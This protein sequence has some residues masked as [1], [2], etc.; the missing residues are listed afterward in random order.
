M[1]GTCLDNIIN[2][3]YTITC[4]TVRTTDTVNKTNLSTSTPSSF[5]A[6]YPLNAQEE[7]NMNVI[8]LN[9]VIQ[10]G[11]FLEGVFISLTGGGMRVFISLTLDG[12][13]TTVT[14]PC[15]IGITIDCTV[16][17]TTSLF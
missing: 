9:I 4:N 5:K 16:R 1:P 2:T 3:L 15:S 10:Q 6:S 13:R 11:H 12:M 14:K 7:R 17:Y 8:Y